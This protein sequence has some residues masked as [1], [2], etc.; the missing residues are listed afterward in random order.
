MRVRGFTLLELLIAIA[1]TAVIAAGSG[2]LMFQFSESRDRI[3]VRLDSLDAFQRAERLIAQDV[4]QWV[5]NRPVRDAFNE[6]LPALMINPVE[7]LVLTRHGR[8]RFSGLL[9]QGS[10]LLRVAL[11]TYPIADDRCRSGLKYVAESLARHNDSGYC[12]VRL[13]MTHLDGGSFIHSQEQVLLAP[14]QGFQVEVVV[15]DAQW[16][17]RIFAQWP[18][19][20]DVL[21]D[22]RAMALQVTIES[23]VFGVSQFIWALPLLSEH[24]VLP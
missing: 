3:Q 18:P 24:E 16:Q 20:A 15:Y 1:V 5:P 17:K 23:E 2:A 13:W 12:L 22:I 10:N 11:K 6:Q 7:G 19:A 4:L 21:L 9:G 8:L 14:I